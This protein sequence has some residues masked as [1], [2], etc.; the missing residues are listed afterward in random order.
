MKTTL[1]IFLILALSYC[2]NSE[3]EL[4]F[5]TIEIR[6]D[7]L[8]SDYGKVLSQLYYDKYNQKSDFP[9]KS[10]KAYKKT[11]SIIK[12]HQTVLK[13]ENV[14]YGYYAIS[15]HHDINNNEKM[16][17]TILGMPDEPFGLSN[18]PK[19]LFSCPDF[20]ETK[21][22]LNRKNLIIHIKMIRL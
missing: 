14:Q 9:T 21:F 1:F 16:D 22:E 12:Y 19:I 13:Y 17:K 2:V 6:I 15:V 20:D 4:Q 3:P 8:E 5:G 7:N 11:S 18:N 10:D